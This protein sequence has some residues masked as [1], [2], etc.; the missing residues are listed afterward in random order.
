VRYPSGHNYGQFPP[1]EVAGHHQIYARY[2][3]KLK[4]G[5]EIYG[6]VQDRWDWLIRYSKHNLHDL[7]GLTSILLEGRIFPLDA[8]PPLTMGSREDFFRSLLSKFPVC[9]ERDLKKR[10]L[11]MG[12]HRVKLGFMCDLCGSRD[13]RTKFLE[14]YYPI[15]TLE[16]IAV[17][18]SNVDLCDLIEREPSEYEGQGHTEG[19]QFWCD[20][21]GLE[22]KPDQNH[23]EEETQEQALARWLLDNCPQ[24]EGLPATDNSRS[25]G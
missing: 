1:G 6:F 18:P 5:L 10:I 21:C 25:E 9:G 4:S 14:P 16:G 20:K 2:I 23:E 15:S 7:I 8:Q 22:P 19:W 17:D 13:L 12:G 11:A 3:P 24:D